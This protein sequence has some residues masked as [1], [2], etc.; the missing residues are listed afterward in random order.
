MII[1][2]LLLGGCRSGQTKITPTI[3]F[4]RIPLVD[5][6][7]VGK[8]AAIEGHVTGSRPG[9]RI[10]L[11]AR[12]GAWYVQPFTDQPFTKIQPDSTWRNSTHLGTE[13]AALLVEPDYHPP[14]RMDVLPLPGGGVVAV[15]VV[16]GEVRLL[17]PLFW[18]TWWFR[19]TGGLAFL[20]ALLAF[21]RI[22]LRQ[23][24]RQLNAR[25]EERLAERAQIAQEIHDTLLQG[26]LSASMQ[27]HVAVDQVP[28]DSPA[29]QRLDHVQQVMGQVIEE[30]RNTIRGMRSSGSDSMDL[31]RAFDLIRQEFASQKQIDFRVV[32]GGR[33]RP[34]HPIL[35]DEAYRIGREA[36]VNAFRHSA[37]KS[38]EVEMEYAASHL[39][40]LVRDDG[41]G[42]D[43]QALRSGSDGQRGLPGMR[44]RAEG[45]GARLKIRSRVRGGTEVE[46]S[47]PSQIAFQIR[48]S[49]RPR[50]WLPGLSLR[51]AGAVIRRLKNKGAG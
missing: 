39:R 7:G 42:I 24:T 20:F 2:C 16:T 35:R 5:E 15:A 46:L 25:F 27:L 30:G 28:E 47:I 12:S 51:R 31:E 17:V 49:T 11:Y 1:C 18:Q 23:L 43:P 13:Y 37:A 10:V 38:I 33:P 22:R 45:I 4:S 8:I 41:C 26:F 32:I 40:I 19:L 21:H 34:L 48:S 14:A 29:K 6:G 9:Q 50:R 44:E 36:L 3:E